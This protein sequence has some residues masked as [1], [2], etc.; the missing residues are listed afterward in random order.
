MRKKV[1][2]FFIVVLLVVLSLS[3]IACDKGSQNGG[4]LPEEINPSDVVK[5]ND[6][7]ENSTVASS[8]KF[9]FPNGASSVFK[10]LFTDEFDISAV[11]YCVIYTNVDTKTTTEGKRGNLSVG[12]IEKITDSSVK[13]EDGT[14]KNFVNDFCTKDGN[15]V[16]TSVKW[17][18]G[19]YT[20]W[21]KAEGIE[22][23][24]AL[25]LQDKLNPTPTVRFFI[26][27]KDNS[28]RIANIQFKTV[29][30]NDGV[31]TVQL[32]EGVTFA[33]WDE[34][35]DTFRM[36][37]EKDS[38][39]EA[40]ALASVIVN[41]KTYSPTSQN[42]PLVIDSSLQGKTMTTAWTN[43]TVTVNFN[44]AVP[45]GAIVESGK[46]NPSD[47]AEL[48]KILTQ[49]VRRNIGKAKA[50]QTD[51]FN[52]FTGYYFAGWYL[53]S[54]TSDGEVNTD[55][56]TL[57]NF[58][59]QVG[60][61][62]I[63]LIA[64]WTKRTYSFTLYTMGGEFVSDVANTKVGETSITD[65]ATAIEK[66]LTVVK[67]TSSFGIESKKITRI[68]FSGLEYGVNYSDYVANV[69][70]AVDKNGNP[71]KSVY[72]KITDIK[73]ALFKGNGEYVKV[74][75]NGVYGEYQCENPVDMT[76]V[77]GQNTVGYIKWVFNADSD[78]NV[79]L[80]R[81]SNYYIDVVF[82]NGISKNAD[83]SLCIEKIADESLSE[84]VIPKELMFD[85]ERRAITE[86]S[87]KACMNLKALT[88]LDLSG[89]TELKK[90]GEYAFAHAP[91]LK[92]I[93]LP[94]TIN[95]ESIGQKLFYGSEYENNY[96]QN[97]GGKQ[98]IVIGHI[99]YKYV[100]QKGAND[101]VSAGLADR[102]NLGVSAYYTEENTF[103]LT[104]EK[105]TALN[106]ELA[107]VTSIAD[108]AFENALN[109]ESITLG[110]KTARIENGA[111]ANLGKLAKI[112]VGEQSDL[113]Y[114][115]EKAFDG[116]LM[117]G[118]NSG[119]YVSDYKAII[120]G[121]VYYR[122][123][124]KTATRTLIPANVR[125]IAP[126]AFDGCD[127]LEEFNF[128]QNKNIMT[129]GKRA[130]TS[131]KW[132]RS[133]NG[134]FVVI[135]GNDGE[136]STKMLVDF[137]SASGASSEHIAIPSDV[138]SIGEE[139]FYLY[140]N[141]V[142][143]IKF[144]TNIKNIENYAFK[145]ATSLE[146][147][148]FTDVDFDVNQNKL[149]NAPS[150]AQNAFADENG[151]LVHNAKFYFTE[152][153]LG[154]FEDIISKK[155]STTDKTTLAWVDLYR[156]NK[157]NF[158]AEDVAAVYIN[159]DVVKT[160]LL[161]TDSSNNAFETIYGTRIVDGLIVRNNT[162]VDSKENLDKNE[163]E[164]DVVLVGKTGVYASLYEEGVT[165]YVV[166]F[167]YHGETKGCH[168]NAGDEHLYVATVHNAIRGYNVDGNT[169]TISTKAEGNFYLTGF[170]G[171]GEENGAPLFYTSYKGGETR[172]VYVDID[173]TKH[174]LPITRIENFDTATTGTRTATVTIDFYGL[175]AYKFSFEYVVKASQIT[176][177]VQDGAISVPL[178]GN[179]ANVLNDFKVRFIGQD[180]SVTVRS[181][182]SGVGFSYGSI[183]TSVLGFHQITV[184]YSSDDVEG[185]V[186]EF[187]LAYSV[188]LEADASL[189]EYVIVNQTET[190]VGDVTYAGEAAIT[191]C[192]ATSA[193]TIVL[194]TTCTIDGKTYLVTDIANNTFEG[195]AKL[196][197]IYLGANFKNIG[198]RAF[199]KCTALENV[200][201]VQKVNEEYAA[202]GEGNF[203]ADKV[204]GNVYNA[205][206]VNLD[207]ISA[208]G[209][210][211]AIGSRYE[212]VTTDGKTLIYNVVGV[213]KDLVVEAGT[214]VFLPDTLLNM[215]TIENATINS[216]S[217]KSGIMFKV[218]P[219]ANDKLEYI[220]TGAF[221]DCSNL[222][223][224]DLTKASRLNYIGA[225]AFANTALDSID[226]S[227]NTQLREINMSTFAGCRYLVEVK[228]PSSIETIADHAFYNCSALTRITGVTEV[229]NLANNAYEGC[230][231]LTIKPSKKT[232]A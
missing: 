148:I 198:S 52:V 74:D 197:A 24:F 54:D 157:G 39:G 126:Y 141:N 28:G 25:H 188:V 192:S 22:G 159:T 62:D 221:E 223:Q 152:K 2:L 113:T 184:R 122:F 6:D 102:L 101:A 108:G 3:M 61:K 93:V 133:Q 15:D 229:K 165:K 169:Q 178:N 128:A 4:D 145:G 140:A 88:K 33:N 118:T 217:S 201:T 228:L 204:E 63:T 172:F 202:L 193:E 121:K 69:T 129:V 53:D 124:D 215:P 56:D 23:S 94:E 196:K 104:A 212:I 203:T 116:T 96:Y 41:G 64:R 5:D 131:T 166:T 164:F 48:Q 176:D 58:S 227:E 18:K 130:F 35:A 222:T 143:T 77:N 156:L 150:I 8:L 66:G 7:D 81:L 86:I 19:H 43:D 173:G 226:L 60:E 167:K 44:L 91:H 147:L 171:Q 85:G 51:A 146:S 194:P 40:K 70:V 120:I 45:S 97:N 55:K 168:I 210:V 155:I 98:F 149:V 127:K 185:Y 179:V 42:F 99:L 163:N 144:G 189:F 182:N 117:L 68:E 90:I 181:I 170:V 154:K 132:I 37:I 211:I 27:A 136:T 214:E 187:P 89:A 103:G 190:S 72:L 106:E 134:G 110:D 31:A 115:G 123:I 100:G 107:N 137:Y 49:S 83:G 161:R 92:E 29:S 199:A 114:I 160:N 79:N 10:S 139:T 200:Y 21:V 73:N 231:K 84:L 142:K 76:K 208:V 219:H 75:E 14:L 46:T 105:I 153:V 36:S 195:F 225:N 209:G 151:N 138:T 119:N 34:F 12:M 186:K 206:I 50:P 162:G 218:V 30:V 32:E 38:A 125:H 80:R 232:N 207:G 177:I 67:A 9:S 180:G 1:S 87:S 175:G 11:E 112:E 109:L 71:S 82:K 13:N 16:V 65:D 216:Y 95:I 213:G 20:V 111:F 59:K 57:W 17:Q 135:E 158:E 26:D 205:T 174:T 230:G 224:I 183:D 220:G 47:N 191:R 78:A